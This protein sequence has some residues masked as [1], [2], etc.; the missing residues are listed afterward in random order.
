MNLGKKYNRAVLNTEQKRN[1]IEKIIFLFIGVKDQS[2]V[3]DS[4]ILQLFIYYI[5][6]WRKSFCVMRNKISDNNAAVC[7]KA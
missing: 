4:E 3:T 5:Q 6:G 2:V 7:L 1:R